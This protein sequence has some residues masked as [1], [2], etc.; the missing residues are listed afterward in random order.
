MAIP[1]YYTAASDTRPKL[2]DADGNEFY[3]PKTFN[4]RSEPASKKQSLMD[5]AFAHGARDVSDGKMTTRVIEIS[6]KIW[7]D[8]DI[9]FN[10]AWDALAVQILK[11][12]F[13]LQDRGRQ[14]NVW[15]VQDI[16]LSYPSKAPRR[17][18][19]V[20][21]Q[22]LCLDPFWYAIVEK[23]KEFSMTTSPQIFEFEVLGNVE[24]HP[25]ITIANLADN[26]DF[27]LKSITDG[28]AEIRIQD[29]SALSGT[30][31]VIDSP[32]GTV[33]RDED[34]DIISAVTGRFPRLLGGRPNQFEYTGAA[35]T[36]TV[37]FREAWL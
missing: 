28:N 37:T 22:F 26:A 17:F 13:K 9:E 19:E 14:I 31:I 18:G 11:E 30:E 24:T 16:Q 20:A 29:A 34:F 5:I 7:A 15:K 35:A 33:M 36:I 32:A 27:K 3:L 23:E 6:G 4:I 10:A 12:G 25:V 2:I 21:L 1:V 8:T